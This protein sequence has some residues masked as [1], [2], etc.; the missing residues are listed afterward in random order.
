MA[1][2][3]NCSVQVTGGKSEISKIDS[4][5]ETVKRCIEKLLEK[6]GFYSY[7]VDVKNI[8]TNGGNYLGQLQTVDIKKKSD[9]CVE[10][11]NLFIKNILNSNENFNYFPMSEVYLRESYV[12]QELLA[13][14]AKFQEQ[15]K[16]PEA[17]RFNIVK[18][19]NGQNSEAIVLEN[20]AKVGFETVNRR[21]VISLKFAEISIAQL[22]KYHGLSFVLQRKEPKYFEAKI[23]SLTGILNFSSE[24]DVLIRR[25]CDTA[26]DCLEGEARTKLDKFYPVFLKKYEHY[27]YLPEEQRVCLCHG[28]FRAN[29]ILMKKTVSVYNYFNY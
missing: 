27:F 2:N 9:G 29:N 11:I 28:D 23:K 22:A 21:D 8:S 1:G 25:F 16:I 17:E 19:Y 6:K 26:I 15:H 14:Y 3:K 10:E 24:W 18:S 13:K 20:L 7:Q 12:Y 4:L 5:S